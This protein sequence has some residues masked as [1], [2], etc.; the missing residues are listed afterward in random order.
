M[1]HYSCQLTLPAIGFCR[2]LKSDGYHLHNLSILFRGLNAVG[3]NEVRHL[4]C[5]VVTS[6]KLLW[7]DNVPCSTLIGIIHYS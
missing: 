6:V 5:Q 2:V 3:L 7:Y 4:Q 1:Y